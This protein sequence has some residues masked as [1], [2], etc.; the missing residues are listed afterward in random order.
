DVEAM[1]DTYYAALPNVDVEALE[2]GSLFIV[3]IQVP[4]GEVGILG[5]RWI[6]DINLYGQAVMRKE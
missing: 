5:P 3:R 4:Y 1:D 6:G 2:R